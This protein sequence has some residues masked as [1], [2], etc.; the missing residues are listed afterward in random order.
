MGVFYNHVTNRRDVVKKSYLFSDHYACCKHTHMHKLIILLIFISICLLAACDNGMLNNPYSRQDDKENILYASFN[1]PPKTLDPAKSYASN[2]YLFTAQIYEPPL[3]Y[4]YLKRPYTL[5]PLTAADMPEVTFLDESG[6]ALPEGANS[7]D[8][9][10]SV[11][12]ITIKPGIYYQPHPA[13]VKDRAGRYIYHDLSETDLAADDISTLSDFKEVA[14][15]ELTADDYVYQIK[16]LGHPQLQSP[17]A[18]LMSAYIQGLDAYIDHL[19]ATSAKMAQAGETHAY[20]DLRE[21]PLAGAE[22][23]DRYR[24]QLKIHDKNPQFK[25]WLAM[26]FFAPVPWEVDRFYQQPGL[27]ARNITLEWYPVGTGPY[28][29]S[30]NNPN[31]R[32]VLT[33]NPNFHGETYPT[34]GEPDDKAKG[35]LADAGKPLPFI[36]MAVF[37]LEKESI[38]RW[39]KFL[40]GY[41]DSSGVSSDSFDQVI[42]SGPIGDLQLTPEMQ[43][44]GIYMRTSVVPGIFFLGFNMLDPVV[45]GDSERARKLRQAIS[46]AVNYEEFIAIFLNGRGTMAH[47]PIPPGIFGYV[48]GEAG[49][50]PVVYDWQG[51]KAVRKSIIEAKKLLTA[52]GYPDGRDVNTGEPLVLHYDVPASGGPDDKAQFDWLRKQFSQLGVQLDIRATQY[53]RFQDKIRTGNAQLFFW[54]WMA[55]YPDPENFL[56]LLYGPNGRVKHGGENS[57]NYSNPN[58]DN[59]FMQMDNMPDGPQRLAIINEMVTILQ[60]DAPWVW[61]FYPQSLTLSQSWVGI[62][63]P[64]EIGNNTLKYMRIDPDKRAQLRHQWNKPIFWPLVIIFGIIIILLIPVIVHYWQKEHRARKS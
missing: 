8:I 45:G 13:F 57:A 38:P 5:I 10:T 24:Y 19:D 17:I 64:T 49:V 36:D 52:A 59:L 32:M 1:S 7:A 9:V 15:R 21:H 48:A 39:N 22:V 26:P 60:H 40:Q 11:Y 54:G 23:I 3:Q 44:L 4:H 18:G 25:Y 6:Q 55:D 28:M 58:Y 14:S 35:L 12:T 53:N 56:F 34:T 16:R 33:R 42:Q 63:K 61:A 47:G 2:E 37:T 27:V 50:N 31:R 51:N 30:E 46:I 43:Q 41:Y 29:L 20:L 62:T